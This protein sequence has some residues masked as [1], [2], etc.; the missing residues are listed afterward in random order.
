VILERTDVPAGILQIASVRLPS[1]SDDYALRM[2]SLSTA[3]LGFIVS[4]VA[5]F[6]I[7]KSK[8]VCVDETVE[9]RNQQLT[10]WK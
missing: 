6:V 4:G 7:A 10:A 8:R 9:R 2:L 1:P 3:D 5:R